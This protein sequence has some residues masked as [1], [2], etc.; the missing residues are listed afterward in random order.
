VKPTVQAKPA[1]VYALSPST[2]LV[3][4]ERG[5][6]YFL[7]GHECFILSASEYARLKRLH[8]AL[9]PVE[10]ERLYEQRLDEVFGPVE[11]EQR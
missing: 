7:R 1:L 11:G 5:A 2:Q 3:A 8:T 6:A 10:G 4:V 9:A